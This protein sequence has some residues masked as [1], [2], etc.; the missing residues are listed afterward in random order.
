M[1]R[2][3]G[4]HV[5][6]VRVANE[7]SLGITHRCTPINFAW[8][9]DIRKRYTDFLV[10]EIRKD[11]SVV[12]LEDYEVDEEQ[13]R[14]ARN[15]QNGQSNFGRSAPS[16]AIPSQ[17]ITAPQSIAQDSGLRIPPPAPTIKAIPAEDKKALADM[18]SE[19]T[20]EKLINL[21]AGVQAK[22]QLPPDE[23]NVVFDPITDRS[24]RA[25]VHQ[26]IRRIF[27]SR[28]ETLADSTGVITAMPAKFT[29]QNR[30]KGQNSRREGNRSTREAGKSFGALG[31]EY[32][33]FTLYKENKDTMDA[34]NTI[35]RLLKIKASNFGF[36]GTK[37]RRA[38]TVQRVSVF[39]QRKNNM[40][41]LNTRLPNLK[42]GHFQHSQSPLQLGQH[43]GNEFVITL[44]NCEP[45]GLGAAGGSV[46]QR[47]RMIQSSVETGLAYLQHHGYLNYFGLQRFGTYSIGTH[48]LGMK[49]LRGDYE[50][51]IDDIL[52]VEDQYFQDVL[53]NRMPQGHGPAGD[54]NRD[55]FNRAKAITTWKAT[56]NAAKAL[57]FLP[58]RFSSEFAIIR[59]LSKNPKDYM[60][61]IL[62]ITRGMRMMYIHAYQSYVWNFMASHRWSKYGATLVE[63]DLVLV[64]RKEEGLAFKRDPEE[65]DVVDDVDDDEL[66]YAQAR[67][68]TAEDVASGKYTIFDVV[69]PTPGFDVTYPQNDIGDS[70]QE[71]MSRDENGGLD[72]FDMRRR[73]KEF[74]LSGNYRHLIGRFITEPE[75][76]IRLYSDDMQQ[77][78]PTD[79]D[80]CTHNKKAE[81]ARITKEKAVSNETA[82]QWRHFA[83][84]PAQYD[85]IMAED[86]RRKASGS[87][88]PE[89]K[90]TTM[91]EIWG[92]TGLDG[93]HKRVKLA[94]HHD[95]IETETK[96]SLKEPSEVLSEASAK[97]FL[98]STIKDE[99]MQDAQSVVKEE[100]ANPVEAVKSVSEAYYESLVMEEP[101]N[102]VEAVKSVSEEYYESLAKANIPTTSGHFDVPEV[103]FPNTR[104]EE[105][106][107]LNNGVL[108]AAT[109]T[110][111]VDPLN[112]YGG[113]LPTVPAPKVATPEDDGAVKTED[114]STVNRIGNIAVPTFRKPSDDPVLSVNN[115]TREM[116]LNPDARKIA[117]VL[118][119]QLKCS[120]YA[121]VVLRELMGT[122]GE[123]S[124][125]SS[126]R[127]ANGMRASSA[128]FVRTSS[129]GGS[130]APSESALMG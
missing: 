41:W 107:S 126:S 29:G 109:E 95:V 88:S 58:K 125:P 2:R 105:P 81:A 10:Y 54:S 72:P 30:N 45:L 34:I 21:D 22:K 31:G 37:D 64:N 65:V 70:Y 114:V 130:R 120:N 50:S 93:S 115:I 116:A 59:H 74:S 9:G 3:D 39:R 55:D 129:V 19:A 63:G 75:Y 98:E 40:I 11:G 124:R 121:T 5:P 17:T 66:Y 26:E 106:S 1:S 69:L 91:K 60:G 104:S 24:Q 25:A 28:L 20:A 87:P 53:D 46:E 110:G 102:P 119:F 44:K 94:R 79:L 99:E 32:L 18:L 118:K 97:H 51:A 103:Q 8:T 62:S 38:A 82:A 117:V 101:A 48:T 78:Y 27:E 90:I 61:A 43:G 123:D 68:L 12:H 122:T 108:S 127:S 96:E 128:G 92:Q 15:Y 16:T 77:M 71:F 6:A 111:P 35:A 36:A 113:M 47:M 67:A 49:I 85:A 7:K 86:R 42:I 83:E 14:L 80:I 84:S 57:E 73:H 76:A 100:P 13:E 112:W 89:G 4:I 33:H 52:N 56:K 23:R